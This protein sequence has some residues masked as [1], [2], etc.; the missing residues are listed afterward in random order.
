[1]A[2]IVDDDNV[3]DCRAILGRA[4]AAPVMPVTLTERGANAH[5]AC[6]SKDAARTV[7]IVM[8]IVG[9]K[10][11]GVVQTSTNHFGMRDQ[12]IHER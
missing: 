9:K 10:L 3:E 2:E 12:L 5:V 7:R 4:D 1:M 8:S 6:S 11:V